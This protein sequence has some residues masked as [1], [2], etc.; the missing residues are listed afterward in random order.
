ME[1]ASAIAVLPA[2]SRSSDGK[3]LTKLVTLTFIAVKTLP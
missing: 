3:R 1:M 2:S